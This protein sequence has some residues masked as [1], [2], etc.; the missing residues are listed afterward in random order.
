MLR[1]GGLA[2]VY[3]PHKLAPFSILARLTPIGVHHF[4]KRV[5]WS[6]EERDTFPVKFRMNSRPELKHVFERAGMQEATYTLL[7]D[8]RVFQRF[9]VLSYL[10]LAIHKLFR[11]AGIQY[12]EVCILGVYRKV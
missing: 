10:E 12:P 4:F 9:F 8:C 11:A 1:P 2:V 7:D 6:T 3:T 5:L